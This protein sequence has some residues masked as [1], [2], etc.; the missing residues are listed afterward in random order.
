M[1]VNSNLMVGENGVCL[2]GNRVGFQLFFLH[3][4]GPILCFYFPGKTTDH[5]GLILN[6][7]MVFF[8]A[9]PA[10]RRIFGFLINLWQVSL[11]LSYF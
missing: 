7:I 2:I 11:I 6:P 4:L 8:Q 3:S 1:K 10:P 9:K 5:C